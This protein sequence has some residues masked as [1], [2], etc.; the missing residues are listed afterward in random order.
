MI[1]MNKMN[2]ERE[3]GPSMQMGRRIKTVR[4]LLSTPVGESKVMLLAVGGRASRNLA[5]SADKIRR[6]A[7]VR[8]SFQAHRCGEL[9]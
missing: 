3:V 8:K 5:Q 2:A 4:I 1:D 6:G 7:G 9:G